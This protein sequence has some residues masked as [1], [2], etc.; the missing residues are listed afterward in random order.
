[1]GISPACRR[2][3]I[4]PKPHGA[5]LNQTSPS[6]RYAPEPIIDP[7]SSAFLALPSVYQIAL[8]GFQFGL[9][10]VYMVK[11]LPNEGDALREANCFQAKAVL[12][13]ASGL[14]REGNYPTL[15]S[16]GSGKCYPHAAFCIHNQQ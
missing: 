13:I 10:V 8:A 2:V 6:W 3:S 14:G 5:V 11:D 4:G 16:Y 7:T 12:Q 9:A 15:L 1:M